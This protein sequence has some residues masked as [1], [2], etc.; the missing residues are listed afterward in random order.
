[1]NGT[2]PKLKVK[3]AQGVEWKVKMGA[4]PQAETAATRFL[5]AAG[6]FVDEDY[7]QAADQGGW[8]AETPQRR[9][10]CIRRRDPRRPFGAQDK[11][12]KELRTLG[13]VPESVSGHP[14][15]QWTPRNDG[16]AE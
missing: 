3:D 13:L 6:Y 8:L 14:G 4:E 5:W 11:R 15:I 12:S 2:S 7:F 10:V 16:F 9:K 1:M